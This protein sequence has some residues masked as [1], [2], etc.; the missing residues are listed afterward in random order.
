MKIRPVGAELARLALPYFPILSNTRCDFWE[1][2][3]E[4]QIC[5]WIFS[6]TYV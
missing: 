6:T 1:Y 5:A 4:H 3:I 2:V